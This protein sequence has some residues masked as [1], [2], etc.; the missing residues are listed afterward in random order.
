MTAFSGRPIR[1]SGQYPHGMITSMRTLLVA[2]ALVAALTI[3]RP[4]LR[5]WRASVGG[6]PPARSGRWREG[7]LRRSSWPSVRCRSLG[8]ESVRYAIRVIGPTGPSSLADTVVIR[9]GDLLVSHGF[10]L[11]APD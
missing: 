3:D 2:L 6:S 1:R 10:L 9:Y 11:T 5:R 7:S 4:A 8:E